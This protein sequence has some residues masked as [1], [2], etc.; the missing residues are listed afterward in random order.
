MGKILLA[1]LREQAELAAKEGIKCTLPG[2][3]SVNG[4]AYVSRDGDRSG[5][6]R[7]YSD[8]NR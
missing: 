4:E 1:W 3:I 5:N 8:A 6:R 7:D 2:T